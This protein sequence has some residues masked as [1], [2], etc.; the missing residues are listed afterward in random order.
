MLFL[1]WDE[2]DSDTTLQH[3]CLADIQQ[4]D[5]GVYWFLPSG[6]YFLAEEIFKKKWWYMYLFQYF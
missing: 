2:L 5:K 3:C 1:S 4:R 6:G